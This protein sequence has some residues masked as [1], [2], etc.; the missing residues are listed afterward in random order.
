[1]KISALSIIFTSKL[2]K[3][4]INNRSG[5]ESGL[6]V[7]AVSK[8]FTE[9]GEPLRAPPVWS[10]GFWGGGRLSNKSAFLGYELPV[11][12]GHAPGG[13]KDGRV[14]FFTQRAFMFVVVAEV[15][16][17]SDGNPSGFD[18]SPA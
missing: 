9:T 6:L 12:A 16:R 8:P 13:G 17:A 4:R 7:A 1:M 3:T 14:G 15:G 2:G 10:L 11:D 18:K 5:R